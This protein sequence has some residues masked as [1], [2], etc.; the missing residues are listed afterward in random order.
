MS[1][2]LPQKYQKMDSQ[3]ADAITSQT[4]GVNPMNE[5]KLSRKW[6][7]T[8]IKE[9]LHLAQTPLL[10]AQQA[11]AKALNE[12]C[13]NHDTEG[14]VGGTEIAHTVNMAVVR[15]MHAMDLVELALTQ[16]EEPSGQALPPESPEPQIDKDRDHGDDDSWLE[17]ASCSAKFLM[18]TA[19]APGDDCPEC[20]SGKVYPDGIPF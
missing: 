11:V 6:H 8:S 5:N 16:L 9:W 12:I 10:N 15:T 2:Y 1:L 17:C 14:M 19:F 13:Q 18:C 7:L 4:K 3:I 20:E